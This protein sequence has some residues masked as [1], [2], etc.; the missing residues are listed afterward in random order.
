MSSAAT[1]T[2]LVGLLSDN[3][4]QNLGGIA[5]GAERTRRI[6]AAAER[7][8]QAEALPPKPFV[9]VPPRIPVFTGRD[10]E[11]ERLDATLMKDKPAAVT[12]TVGRAAVQGLGGVSKTS[13]AI[14]YA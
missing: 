2:P 10:D 13:L 9:G 1:N 4:Y 5:D 7:H 12:Q 11:L 3:V 14:E 8:S 6:I